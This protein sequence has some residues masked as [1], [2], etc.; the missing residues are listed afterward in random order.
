MWNT[1]SQA[2]RVEEGRAKC[3]SLAHETVDPRTTTR[4]SEQQHQLQQRPK[5]LVRFCV[6]V[7]NVYSELEKKRGHAVHRQPIAPRGGRHE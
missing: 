6:V 3:T 5:R 4:T 7:H 2:R 1:G